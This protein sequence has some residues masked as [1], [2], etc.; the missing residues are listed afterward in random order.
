[1]FTVPQEG[2]LQAIVIEEPV[3]VHNNALSA[4]WG[5]IGYEESCVVHGTEE[6]L[7]MLWSHSKQSSVS[8]QNVFNH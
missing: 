2:E 6:D 8:E 7:M 5:S 4:G 3:T 1:M